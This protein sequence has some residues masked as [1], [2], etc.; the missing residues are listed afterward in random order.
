ML[1]LQRTVRFSVNPPES[2]AGA[3]GAEATAPGYSGRPSMCG[4]GRYY[5][6]EVRCRGE[7]DPT[8][9]YLLN[10]QDIDRAV[11]ASVVPIVEKACRERPETDPASLMAEATGA[12]NSAL[13]G[14]LRALRW[15][16][17]PYYS[18]EMSPSEPSRVV[19]REQF[20][21]AAS[22]RLHVASLSDEENRRLF[23]KC[24]NA[25]G[26]GHNYRVEPAVAVRVGPGRKPAL[27]LQDLERLVSEKV[28][29]R[30]DH[31]NL[32]ED[33][34]EFSTRAGGVNPSV[35][36]IAKVC[37]DLLAPAVREASGGEADLLAVT[38]WETDRTSSTYPA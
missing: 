27:S 11:R 31:R 26:H 13:G 17:T 33:T 16:L 28:V 3:A 1:T 25:L 24:N 36:N 9:G 23:G 12:L 5:E 30:F 2:G 34:V 38:V 19:L 6:V 29:E 21:F 4:L 14:S 15:R 32:N 35:E 8:T 37:Y 18:V 10:I 22:H 7:V 20:D